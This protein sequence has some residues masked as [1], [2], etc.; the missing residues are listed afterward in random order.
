MSSSTWEPFFTAP[1]GIGVAYDPDYDQGALHLRVISPCCMA[2]IH[3]DMEVSSGR[4]L[5]WLC[6]ECRGAIRKT[7]KNWA[8]IWSLEANCRPLNEWLAEWFDTPAEEIEVDIQ[9]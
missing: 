8:S 1:N 4:E 3:W 7:P 2:A 9:V 6:S 5:S